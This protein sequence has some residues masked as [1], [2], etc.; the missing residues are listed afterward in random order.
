[1]KKIDLELIDWVEIQKIHDSGIFWNKL[2]KHIGISR[3]VLLRAEKEGLIKK[4]LHE[5]T[6]SDESKKK[7]SEGR[8]KYL[9]DNPDKHP[10]KK[11][12]KFKSVPCEL[13]KTELTKNNILFLDEFQPSDVKFYSIDIVFPNHK[14]G[15]EIN[16]NQ[17]YNND[18]TLKKYYQIRHDFLI[19]LGWNIIEIHYS[20]VYNKLLLEKLINSIK[21]YSIKP[22]E[23]ELQVS[24]YLKMKDER[25]EKNKQHCVDCGCI[26][27]KKS[28]RCSKCRYENI[29]KN[30]KRK[31]KPTKEELEILIKNNSW[32]SIGRMFNITGSSVIKWSKN[33]GIYFHKHNHKEL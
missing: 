17:H 5:R 19:N 15:I 11:N 1:M 26:V 9:T 27:L 4:K 20:V 3:T 10:W 7:I 22:E 33:Y 32:E 23:Y 31:D 21:E 8:K 2:H 25:K 6:Q 24:E 13:L 16:G 18:G 30:P 14:I 12:S 28:I 29:K